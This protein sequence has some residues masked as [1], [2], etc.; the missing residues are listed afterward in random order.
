M[1]ASTLRPAPDTDEI[2]VGRAGAA[3]H[4]V[5]NRPRA[6]NALTTAMVTQVSHLLQEWA[7]DPQVSVVT[8]SGAGERGLC[9]GGD[10]VAARAAVE[11]GADPLGFFRDEYAMNAA[12]VDFAKP[13]VAFM[14]GV[15]M[16]GGVGISAYAG[17]RL[18]TERTRL[19]MP[20]TIIGFFPDVGILHLLARAPGQLG[21]HLALTG[22]TI[23]GADAVALGLADRVVESGAWPALVHDLEQG[24]DPDEAVQTAATG[25]SSGEA[26]LLAQ[27]S[28]TQECY[29]SGDPATILAQLES[30]PAPGAQAAAAAIRAR[31]PLSVA[32]TVEALRRAAQLP[33][34]Q[35]VLDQDLV[36]AG[37]LVREGDFAEGVRAQLVDKDRTPKWRDASVEDISRERVLALFD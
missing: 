35:A 32:A 25:A 18:V 36:L 4:L 9:A 14:D 10:V 13:V 31:S 16:G 6:I 5:L 34:V 29:A 27:R 3:A 8:I 20:E 7:A 19:A 28:W 24:V 12:L 1:D 33:T 22:S 21:T 23:T 17:V 15:V 11:A 2:L 26:P 30:H 37:N